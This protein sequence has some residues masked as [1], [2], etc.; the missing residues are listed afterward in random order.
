[1]KIKKKKKQSQTSKISGSCHHG[2]SLLHDA[3]AGTVFNMQGS[4]E[5]IE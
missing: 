2:M 5:Y 4:C 3:D 1:M